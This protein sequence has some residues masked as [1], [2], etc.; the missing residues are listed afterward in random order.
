VAVRA[1]EQ[2]TERQLLEVLLI[3]SG[4]DIAQILAAQVA[5]SETRFIAEMNAEARALGMD[6]GLT[7]R[8]RGAWPSSPT[9]RSAG[10][11]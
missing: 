11:S 1:G 7:P 9:R 4:N 8:P 6:P 3:P 10:V 5:G 2:L